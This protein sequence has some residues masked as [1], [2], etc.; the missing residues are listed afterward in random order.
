ML[1]CLADS[2]DPTDAKAMEELRSKGNPLLRDLAKP[3]AD[4]P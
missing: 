4:R 2:T 3:V 1:A